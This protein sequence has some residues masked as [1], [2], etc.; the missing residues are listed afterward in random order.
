[1]KLYKTVLILFLMSA[2]SLG[3]AHGGGHK[4]VSED[5]I[6]EIA[7]RALGQLSSVE[8]GLAIG[9]LKPTWA[10][11]DASNI[12]IVER[13]RGYFVVKAYNPQESDTT[14]MLI[15]AAG[16]LYDVNDTGKFSGVNKE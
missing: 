1:M 7:Q 14:Y 15:S 4:Q 3:M 9:K 13:G 8:H 2:S 11:L 16:E 12:E 5:Q 10:K 6:V